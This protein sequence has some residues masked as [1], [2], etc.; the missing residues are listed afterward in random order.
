MAGLHFHLKISETEKEK[1]NAINVTCQHTG[2]HCFFFT[3]SV[4]QL[5]NPI[6]R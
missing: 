5:K 3:F 4:F 6:L 1:K 2:V